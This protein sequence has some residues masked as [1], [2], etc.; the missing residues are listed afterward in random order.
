MSLTIAAGACLAMCA[1]KRL[2]IP[3]T[4]VN[5]PDSRAAYVMLHMWDFPENLADATVA[6]QSVRDLLLIASSDSASAIDFAAAVKT[7]TFKATEAGIDI[8]S[9]AE[10]LTADPEGDFFNDELYLPFVE[11]AL[12]TPKLLQATPGLKERLEYEH[13]S[14]LKNRVGTSAATFDV[15]LMSGDIIPV[16]RLL[17]APLNL[18]ILFDPDCDHCREILSALST[19]PSL[20]ESIEKGTVNVIAVWTDA[21]D[22]PDALSVPAAKA[23]N[24]VSDRTGIMDKELYEIPVT[25]TVYVIDSHGTVIAKNLLDKSQIL[26]A[27]KLAD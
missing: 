16:G 12:A 25:P 4:D 9:I 7:L 13:A 24:V 19:S 14:R 5:T 22:S 10:T 23:W 8:M 27:L 21:Q 2:P 17:T 20:A 3:P 11:A 26:D 6:T 18:L 15:Q 1:D